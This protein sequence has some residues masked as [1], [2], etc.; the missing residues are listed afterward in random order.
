MA[1]E[2]GRLYSQSPVNTVC[3]PSNQVT[4]LVVQTCTHIHLMAK[5]YRCN[6]SVALGM[7]NLN[8]IPR[9]E[10]PHLPTSIM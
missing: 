1:I 7:K 4:V 6:Y 10:C 3:Y 8:I 2:E 5:M 9:I